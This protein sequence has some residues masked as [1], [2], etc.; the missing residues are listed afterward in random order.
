[1]ALECSR[2]HVVVV[3]Y[4][5][6]GHINPMLQFSKSL[7]AKGKFWKTTDT[8]ALDGLPD[9]SVED[10][11]S[12]ILPSNS[13]GKRLL[14]LVQEQMTPISDSKWILGNSFHE[15]ESQEVN[16]MKSMGAAIRPVGPLIPWAFLDGRDPEDNDFGA[17]LWKAAD[18]MEW[19][20]SKAASTVVYVSFGSVAALS[21]EQIG[22]IAHGLQSSGHAFLWVMI[23]PPQGSG[24]SV[25]E[26]L[27]VGFLEATTKQGLV[28]PWSPQ[29]QVLSHPSVGSFV[30]HCGW[31]STL[32]SLCLGVPVLAVPQWGDQMT[33]SKY[34]SD[35]WKIG[36]R[37]K[38]RANG[39]VGREEV[40]RCVR[41]VMESEDGV[42]LRNNALKLKA[43]AREAIAEGGSF[44]KNIQEFVNDIVATTSSITSPSP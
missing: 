14:Q 31:N 42:E 16:A 4:P 10:I 21:R 8:I 6:Q 22:E 19:L 27:P 12:F 25:E 18:C 28:V 41:K 43:L 26:R 24:S 13:R 38:K 39:V 5:S 17:N 3:P 9:M 36:L 44:D 2:P 35:V 32:E 29:L 11:P 1:M 20:N 34:I 15:L 30:T 37:L 23:P 7:A 33:N 40:E